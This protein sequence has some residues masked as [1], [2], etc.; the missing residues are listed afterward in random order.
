MKSFLIIISFSWKTSLRR[1]A[2][3]SSRGGGG[4]AFVA[5]TEASE[6]NKDPEIGGSLTDSSARL[7]RGA[8]TL[9]GTRQD[10]EEPAANGSLPSAIIR[11]A[12]LCREGN[13][14]CLRHLWRR[15]RQP[16]PARLRN[17]YTSKTWQQHPVLT[18]AV[19]RTVFIGDFAR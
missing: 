16:E 13:H 12:Q 17:I 3:K 14:T 18:A 5:V 8:A 6:H 2:H 11:G 7:G 9:R 19:M 10:P 1:E 4:P 15:R